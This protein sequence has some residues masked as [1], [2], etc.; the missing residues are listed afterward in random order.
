MKGRLQVKKILIAYY[1]HSGNTEKIAKEIQNKTGG[2]LFEIA[3]VDDYPK[4]YKACVDQ[5]GKEIKSGFLPKLVKTKVENI[6]DYDL[7]FIGSPNWW[8]TIAP[9]VSAFLT[10]NDFAGKQVAAFITHGGGGMN[11][12]MRD[13]RNLCP[14]CEFTEPLV[15]SGS[16]SIGQIV[17][18]IDSMDI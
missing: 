2:T 18:W 11:N 1:S 13:I 15:L 7:V 5:A 14:N 4:D 9:P 3:P 17:K 12:T 16:G 8:S 6:A 10:E